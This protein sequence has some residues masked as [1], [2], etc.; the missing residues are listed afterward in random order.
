MSDATMQSSP[1]LFDSKDYKRSRNSY[2]IECAFEYF[3]ALLVS[4]AFLV[5]LLQDIGMNDAT[6]GI[7]ASLISLAFVFQLFSIFVVQRIS[8]TKVFAII[9]HFSSQ[10]FF[11]ALYFVPFLPAVEGSNYKHVLAVACIMIAYFGNYLVTSIIYKWGN[12]F[13]EPH[14]RGRYCATKEMISL[15]SGM[16]VTLIIGYVMDYFE[17]ANNLHG[18]FL[19]AAC[20]I[21]VFSICD[22]VCLLLIKNDKKPKEE[23]KKNIVPMSEVMRNTL[24]NRN[25][26]SVLLLAVLWEVAKGVSIGFMG[27][28]RL[29]PHELALTVGAVQIINMVGNLMRFAISRPFGK[30]SDKYSYAKGIELALVMAAVSFVVYAFTAPGNR[31]FVWTMVILFSV[32]YHGC[33]AGIGQNMHSI[34]YSYVDSRYFVQASAIK[35]SV[36]GLC[37]FG[38]ALLASRFL[39]YVQNN[40]NALFGIHIYGQQVLATFSVILTLAAL[41]VAHFVVSKQKAMVQ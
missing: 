26:L 32:L 33:Q 39:Q 5:K 1:A 20:G 24:G 36:G 40:G 27:T 9:F 30:F 17:A 8:N 3:V 10:V 37:H 12:S 41:L 25:F 18:G 16:V 7:M 19:F 6:V 14:H 15:I 29:N 21:F 35:S 23:I 4:D 38:S 28:Y 31:V 11:M 2:L 13:V 22:L 34:L